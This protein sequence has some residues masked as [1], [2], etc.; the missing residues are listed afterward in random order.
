MSRIVNALASA[1]LLVLATGLAASA[2]A[3]TQSSLEAKSGDAYFYRGTGGVS[4]P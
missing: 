2:Q 1:L 4:P 3:Q